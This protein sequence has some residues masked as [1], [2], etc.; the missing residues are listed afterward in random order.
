MFLDE[1]DGNIDDKSD[2]E[3]DGN[4][5]LDLDLDSAHND[6]DPELDL[7]FNSEDRAPSA[8]KFQ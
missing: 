3:L 5:Q 8:K 2:V 6:N 7:L 1:E 4:N